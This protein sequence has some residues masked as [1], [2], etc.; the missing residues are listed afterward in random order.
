MRTKLHRIASAANGDRKMCNL[1]RY[2][3]GL[4]ALALGLISAPAMAQVLED[5]RC[6]SITGGGWII[7]P[8]GGKANFGVGG[9][10]KRDEF[11]GHLQYIDRAALVTIA[12]QTL[13][14][15]LK[16]H[17]LEITGYNMITAAP[18]GEPPESNLVRG[19]REICGTARTNL[20]SPNN[21]VEFRVRVQDN[22][23]P[24]AGAPPDADLF[25]LLL[26]PR[27]SVSG[28]PPIY[29]AVNF[30]GGG[31]IKLHKPNRDRFIGGFGIVGR[32]GEAGPGCSPAVPA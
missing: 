30:L 8:T 2:L 27:G 19:Q 9:G 28:T 17:W 7:G 25:A 10:C 13:V 15:E 11:W 29:F 6:D 24:G 31:N 22:G 26:S 21:E 32:Q 4:A 1:K 20:P 23:E 16:V 5:L 3:I 14:V 12:G 18:P